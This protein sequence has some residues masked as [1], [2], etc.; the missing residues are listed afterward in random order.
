MDG[1]AKVSFDWGDGEQTFRLTIGGLREL[2]AKCDAGPARI[3]A[4]LADG[5][6][7]VDDIRETLRLGL[8]GGGLAPTDALIKVRRYVDE[9]PLYENVLPAVVVLGAAL[10]GAP[11]DAVGEA[12]AETTATE[13]TNASSSRPSMAP[14]R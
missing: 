6:W 2:Q 8:I 10:S 9:R 1:S 13:A 14:A 4:R 5:S 3:H 11:G 7:R 12:T